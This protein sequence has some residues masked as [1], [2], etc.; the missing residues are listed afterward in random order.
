VI[1]ATAFLTFLW[2][3]IVLFF[4]ITYFILFFHVLG[5]LT[6]RHDASGG[7]KA[8]WIVALIVLPYLGVLAYYLTNGPGMTERA[9]RSQKESEQAFS[10]YVREAAGT[11]GPADQVAKAQELLDRGT[12]SESEFAQLKAKA[13]TT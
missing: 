3:L 7:K 12:I 10:A 9:V 5:D 1:V 13:L 11:A 8:L 2:S 4:M 6:R